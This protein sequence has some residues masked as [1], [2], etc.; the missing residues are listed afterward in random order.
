MTIEEV[1]INSKF[2]LSTYRGIDH[3]CYHCGKEIEIKIG[4]TIYRGSKKKLYCKDCIKIIYI[5]IPDSILDD[6]D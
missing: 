6:N 1:I 4:S 2:V 3:N 5:D